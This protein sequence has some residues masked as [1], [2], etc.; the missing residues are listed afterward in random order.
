VQLSSEESQ[1]RIELLQKK[2]FE[3]TIEKAWKRFEEAEF[4]PFLIKGWAAAQLYT[5]TYARRYT[6]KEILP[7]DLH[8]ESSKLVPCGEIQIRV[9]RAED[10]LRVLCFHWLTDGGAKKEKLWVV[11]Y[12]VKNRPEDLD[13]ERCLGVIGKKRRRW[14]ICTIGLAH[15]YLGLFIDDLNFAAEAKTSIIE[16][17]IK[18]S[19]RNGKVI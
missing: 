11:Y 9:L 5:E 19:N 10:H 17:I 2:V 16:W 6:D 7:V 14:I 15:T 18:K 12:A 8:I 3:G 4:K 13:R 1:K